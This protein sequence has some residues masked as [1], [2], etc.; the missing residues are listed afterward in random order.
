MSIMDEFTAAHEAWDVLR[1]SILDSTED[2]IASESALKTL[3]EE[4]GTIEQAMEQWGRRLEDA[5]DD[6]EM[7]ALEQRAE[8]VIRYGLEDAWEAR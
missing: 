6:A 7:S 2:S 1:A 8:H 3:L 5:L 4:A